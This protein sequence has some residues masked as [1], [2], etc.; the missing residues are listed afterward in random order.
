MNM[1][2]RTPWMKREDLAT[3]R[4]SYAQNFE[5]ILLARAFTGEKGFYIDVGASHP[6]FHSVTKLFYDRG[7]NGINIEPNPDMYAL[8]AAER[9]R[10]V[11]VNVGIAD[12][13]GL[14][15]FYE[16]TDDRNELSTFH[17]EAAAYFR[18]QGN[19]LAERPVAVTTLA[20]VCER[21]VTGEIDFL[22]ID[23]ECLELQV[24]Q[25]GDWKRWRPRV[26]L[27]EAGIPEL[28]AKWE[29]EMLTAGYDL[30]SFDGLN[31]YYT[32]HEDRDLIAALAAP[33]SVVD[34]AFQ[35]DY[36]HMIEGLAGELTHLGPSAT[37]LAS[38]LQG[39]AHR[40][41]RI[42]AVAKR[43]LRLAS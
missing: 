10:D 18:S 1:D 38:R 11:N 6:T 13:P 3:Y 41:R 26:V 9:P 27:L 30:A 35:Y 43:L 20:D 23:V 33:V 4:I 15:T 12:H 14:L 29:P 37:K 17:P 8:L 32:R 2:A 28:V 7:W 25:G 39:F 31:K 5:D 16:F 24:I 21:Y 42:S 19:V 34:R 36:L 40:H 22:K